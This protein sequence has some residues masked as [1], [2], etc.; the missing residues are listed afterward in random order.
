[1]DV[2]PFMGNS[3]WV[4]ADRPCYCT[5]LF[6]WIGAN[7]P[8]PATASAATFSTTTT[9]A[10][11]TATRLQVTT[12]VAATA[13]ETT[14]TTNETTATTN[15]TTATTNATNETPT[16]TEIPVGKIG[17]TVRKSVVLI[18]ESG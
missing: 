18:G 14:A 8:R 5:C 17:E 7:Y 11:T 10:A 3:L 9:N 15:E 6:S 2:K 1:V 16:A 4:V 13:N 12:A